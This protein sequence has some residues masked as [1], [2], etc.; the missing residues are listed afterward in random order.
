MNSKD[1]TRYQRINRPKTKFQK[2]IKRTKTELMMTTFYPILYSIGI[3]GLRY[4]GGRL[5]LKEFGSISYVRD[6]S[7]SPR[8]TRKTARSFEMETCFSYVSHLL[9]SPIEDCLA[10][11]V[12]FL[13]QQCYN[14]IRSSVRMVQV[15]RSDLP[16]LGPRSSHS[17]DSF[18]GPQ[19]IHTLTY[20]FMH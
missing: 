8:S 6:K 11:H 9:Y 1:S 4:Q 14:W 2:I 15:G 13:V 5:I 7:K 12:D 17:F 3:F 20:G 10:S 19:L 18:D 16:A